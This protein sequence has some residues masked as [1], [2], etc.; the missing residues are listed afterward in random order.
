MSVEANA[1][2]AVA[3]L[4]D[5]SPAA[6]AA[7]ALGF[8]AGATPPEPIEFFDPHFHIWDL[9]TP[10]TEGSGFPLA[11]GHDAAILFNPNGK[12]LYD[13]ADYESDFAEVT[14]SIR[15]VGGAWLEAASVC[16]VDLDSADPKYAAACLAEAK[17]SAA[18]LATAKGTY[19][20]VPTMPLETANTAE[21]LASLAAIDGVRGIRQIVNHQ[22][23]WPRNKKLGDLLDSPAWQAGFAELSKVGFSFDLQLNP[24]QYLKAAAVIA[25]NPTTTVIINHLGCPTLEDLTERAESYFAGMEALAAAGNVY[26]KISMLCYLTKEWDTS[27]VAIDAVHRIIKIFGPTKCFFASNYPVDNWNDGWTAAKLFA[28]FGKLASVY[29]T[30]TQKALFAGNARAAYRV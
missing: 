7:Y 20:L 10:A 2:E 9:A 14:Q 28:A 5:V 8:V 12:P 19:V 29:D 30:S 3:N 21:L 13:A 18:R 23:D 11:S 25:A 17:W 15:H 6:A 24:P 22:P 26:I 16:H 4:G 1:L 27:Q